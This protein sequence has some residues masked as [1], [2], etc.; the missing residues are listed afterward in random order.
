MGSVGRYIFRAALGAF[1]VVLISI[2]ALMWITQ[3]LRNFDLMTNQGQSF[4][5]F[6]GITGLIIPMLVMMIAP[7]ALMVAVA[8]VLTRLSNDS[9]LIVLNAAGMRP[10]HVFRPF[11]LLGLLVSLLVAWIAFYFSPL[12]LQTARRWATQV[13]AEIVTSNVQPGRFIVIEGKLTLQIRSREPSGQLR[14]IMVDDQRDA[15][16]RGTIF[17]ERG[18][19]IT[20]ERGIFLLLTNGAVH[21]QEAGKRDPLIVRFQEYAFDLSRLSPNTGRVT[22]SVHERSI[23]DLLNPPA[24]DATFQRSPGMFRAEL[25]NRIALPLYPLAFLFVIFTF[26]GAP[27]TSRQSRA[28]SLI[29]AIA[30]VTVVRALGFV[31]T[32]SGA[33]STAALAVPYLALAAAFAIGYLVIRRGIALEAP[34]PLTNLVNQAVAT[35]KERLALAAGQ[36]P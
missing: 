5:V 18:D 28:W 21:R 33:H 10:W 34:A 20:N 9:E 32:I 22:Y 6:V 4:L 25:H 8:H 23:W 35:L 17:A 7:I 30:V 2:T 27:R 26:L 15:K 36:R 14:G 19:L 31:G 13:R 3:A 29:A 1:L 16:E 12:C 11:L 24:D